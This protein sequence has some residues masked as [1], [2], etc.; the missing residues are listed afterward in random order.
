MARRSDATVRIGVR[1]TFISGEFW[2]FSSQIA[3][4]SAV[5]ERR[6][7]NYPWIGTSFKCH[8][9]LGALWPYYQR[10]L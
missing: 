10:R 4:L 1:A 5:F 9:A 3:A 8:G 6:F 7:W 2:K